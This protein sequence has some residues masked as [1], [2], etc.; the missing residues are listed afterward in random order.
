[1]SFSSLLRR[2][3]LSEDADA[4]EGGKFASEDDLIVGKSR[5]VVAPQDGQLFFVCMVKYDMAADDVQSIGHRVSEQ[6]PFIW[7]QGA[8]L[9]KRQGCGCHG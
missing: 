7:V 2:F 3:Q 8:Y 5:D 9:G 1:M 6:Y 4:V